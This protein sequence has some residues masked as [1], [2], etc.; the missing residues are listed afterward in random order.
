MPPFADIEDDRAVEP[1]QALTQTQFT[2]ALHFHGF[3][4]LLNPLDL[5]FV[6]LR[7]RRRMPGGAV[8]CVAPDGRVFV[9]RL[10]TLRLL[11]DWRLECTARRRLRR[12]K[13][14]QFLTMI[15]SWLP[16][17]SVGASTLAHV[18][19]RRLTRK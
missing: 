6:D 8:R 15:S 11:L 17:F 14:H 1:V 7:H 10:A 16:R 3:A 18:R 19:S 5:V 13:F 2:R 12:M 9:D 4:V